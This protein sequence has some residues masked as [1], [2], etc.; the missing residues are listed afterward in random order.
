MKGLLRYLILFTLFNETARCQP[1]TIIRPDGVRLPPVDI[2]RKVTQLMDAAGVT[3][4]SLGI[5]QQNAPV[6][7]QAYGFR[8]KERRL[9]NDTST[10]FYAASFSKAVFAYLVMQLVDEGMLDLD[11]P[12]YRYLPQALSQ[13]PDFKDLGGDDRW[14]MITSRHCL[15]HSSGL[16]NWRWANPRGNNKLEIFFHPGERYSY[17]GEGI[18]LLQLVVESVTGQPLEE[19]MQARVFQPLGMTRSSFLWRLVF[20]KNHALPY[21]EDE[22]P[23][24]R[25]KHSRAYAAGSMET[26]IADYCR[27]ISAVM[28]ARGISQAS[29]REMV[30]MQIPIYNRYQFPPLSTDSTDTNLGIELSY[31]LGWG[32]F[33]GAHGL[34]F[35]KEGHGEGFENYNINFPGKDYALVIL[36]NSANAESIFPELVDA[37]AGEAS[38][39]W[40]WEGYTRYRPFN[41]LPD[42]LLKT[43]VGIYQHKDVRANISMADGH[44]VVE[45]KQERLPKTV[46]YASNDSVF[47]ARSVDMEVVFTKSPWGMVKGLR[48]TAGGELYE[49]RKIK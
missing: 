29:Y 4:L 32:I 18:Q 16:L 37:L 38:I 13:Y 9:Y 23:L 49:M 19:L 34:S 41:K 10:V 6:Y 20:E 5:L 40:E 2:D 45:S 42:S 36:S 1:E 3:G 28:N 48:L 7:V 24:P 30:S 14:R 15:S 17:S 25:D 46:L 47:F 21:N 43:Y 8:N 35:F 44:L 31:G 27:F 39:P 11:K 22:R 33:R 26:T 12:L